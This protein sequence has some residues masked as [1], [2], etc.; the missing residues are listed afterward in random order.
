MGEPLLKAVTDAAGR[1]EMHRAPPE[2]GGL[3]LKIRK[4]GLRG[5]PESVPPGTD[6]LDI[7]VR[8]TGS[9]AFQ[10]LHEGGWA[11]NVQLF[12]AGAREPFQEQSYAGGTGN[13]SFEALLP[14]EYDL[15]W[16]HPWASERGVVRGLRV[17]ASERTADPRLAPLDLRGAWPR[18]RLRIE[19]EAG[20]PVAG[21][22]LE[23]WR[24]GR[25]AP[26]VLKPGRSEL[27]V[28]AG[29]LPLR[30][31]LSATGFR[32]REL[33]LSADA[34]V[35]LTR[36]PRLRLLVPTLPE[37]PRE[38]EWVA[39]IR[40][41][42]L[43]EPWPTPNTLVAGTNELMLEAMGMHDLWVGA[44]RRHGNWND[45][46]GG[47][48]GLEVAIEDGVT[49]VTL[50]PIDASQVEAVLAEIAENDPLAPR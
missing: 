17:V 5:G 47:G 36:G 26:Y 21:A 37:L 28:V 16:S 35:V 20:A 48:P 11:P 14:G 9:L 39:W 2:A 38:W 12:Q 31:R 41:A 50:P 10:L 8:A 43:R 25:F 44:V 42:G 46:V 29:P 33:E 45:E 15:E 34:T 18:V 13:R 24:D 32:A 49:T 4:P 22:R 7:V 3:A 6:G 40:P 30:A 27:D 23:L 1:F 19:D